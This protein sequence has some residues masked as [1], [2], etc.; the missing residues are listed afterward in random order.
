MSKIDD[1]RYR[2]FP[3]PDITKVKVCIRCGSLVLNI[4]WHNKFHDNKEVA[5]EDL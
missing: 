3:L 5:N 2:E 1:I 4:D